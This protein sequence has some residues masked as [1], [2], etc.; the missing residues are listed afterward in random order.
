MEL[1][2]KKKRKKI[3]WFKIVVI[4]ILIIGF[5][6]IYKAIVIQPQ[7]IEAKRQANIDT[8]LSNSYKVYQYNW[9]QACESENKTTDCSLSASYADRVEKAYRDNKDDCYE[10]YKK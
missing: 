4:V 10:R 6:S 7:K 1:K 5:H 8:C 2:E 9:S 3:N